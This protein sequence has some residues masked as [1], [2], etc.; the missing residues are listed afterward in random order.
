M[1]MQDKKFFRKRTGFSPKNPSFSD[2]ALQKTLFL[3]QFRG[4]L[5][6]KNSNFFAE[7]K[8]LLQSSKSQKFFFQPEGL[9]F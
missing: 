9:R 7:E 8:V 3:S 2:L 6:M 1:M 4:F 5:K